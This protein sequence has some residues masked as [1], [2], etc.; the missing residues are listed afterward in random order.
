MFAKF[1]CFKQ[2]FSATDVQILNY[3]EIALIW[4][5]FL[6]RLQFLCS[7]FLLMFLF[8]FTVIFDTKSLTQFIFILDYLKRQQLKPII[9]FLPKDS[10]SSSTDLQV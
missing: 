10:Q 4:Q 8:T 6:I 3:H 5:S 7:N 2:I 9:Y 1:D